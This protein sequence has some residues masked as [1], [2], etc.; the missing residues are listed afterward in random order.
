MTMEEKRTSTGMISVL[1][2]IIA[3]LALVLAWISY[4]KTGVDLERKLNQEVQELQ[5]EA[6]IELVQLET[7]VR[8]LSLRAEVLA[9]ESYEGLAE[10]AVD[11]RNNLNRAY[12]NASVEA[13]QEIQELDRQLETLESELRTDSANAV[14]TIQAALEILERDIRTEEE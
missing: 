10:E 5:R 9:A 3:I 12:D 14:E 4:N 8:L 11:I 6:R 2:L 1:A 7:R 13:R